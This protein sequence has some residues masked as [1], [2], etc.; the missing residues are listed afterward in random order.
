MPNGMEKGSNKEVHRQVDD[1]DDAILQHENDQKWLK[2]MT[3]L[4]TEYKSTTDSIRRELTNKRG[5]VSG[6]D[7]WEDIVDRFGGNIAVKHVNSNSAGS[8][9]SG[10]ESFTY[11]ELDLFA[12]SVANWGIKQVGLRAGDHVCLLMENRAEFYGFIF[13]LA[14]V[15]VVVPLLNTKLKGK[16]LGHCVEISK[17]KLVISSAKHIENWNSVE[18]QGQIPKVFVYDSCNKNNLPELNFAS[19]L[20]EQSKARPDKSLRAAVKERDPMFCI[21]TSGTTGKPKAA[22]F[23]HLRFIGAGITWAGPS[24]LSEADNYYIPLPL[25][26]GNALAVASSPC[27]WA[28]ATAVVRDGFSAS[29]FLPDLRRF[30][31]TKCVYI[32]ELWRYVYQQEIRGDENE[33]PLEVIIGNGLR[34]DLWTKVMKRFGLKRVVE[35]YG[36]TEMPGGAVL[37]W[38]NRPGSCGFYPN[39]RRAAEGM[40]KIFRF[41]VTTDSLVRDPKTGLA[42]ECAA[43][44]EGELLM[45]LPDKKYDGYLDKGATARKLYSDVV[46]AGDLWWSSGDILKIDK[47][48]FYYFIDRVG[49]SFRWKGENVSTAEVAD[50]LSEIKDVGE[51]AV[52]GVSVKNNYGKAGM[53]RISGKNGG[54]IN[55]TKLYNFVL[56][57][58]PKYACPLFLRV[59]TEA[60]LD[61]TSTLKFQKFSLSKDGYDPIRIAENSKDLVFFRDET[62]K[63]FIPLTSEVFN[64]INSNHYHL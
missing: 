18:L 14:K 28:G 32:G 61:K 1:S 27:F 20:A 38:T 62:K 55:L 63:Q 10:K 30:E 6:A 59:S 12:N 29:N 15:G 47:D 26:H 43:G 36:S 56:D 5:I 37:N 64:L 9:H 19:T 40:D 58:L 13:G 34:A 22:K 60:S 25:Y 21:F 44:E 7:Y 24:L 4:Y 17:P 45:K 11:E 48:G 53:A 39:E 16:V 51:V 41:D 8:K 54:K 3:H 50:V 31:C 33:S 2:E 52:Y 23:S 42:E 46:E 57:K 49:D 35:H